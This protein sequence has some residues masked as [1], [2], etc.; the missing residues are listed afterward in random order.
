MVDEGDV[1]HS[2]TSVRRDICL[3]VFGA[4][5]QFVLCTTGK[6]TTALSTGDVGI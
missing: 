6:L 4:M 1:T 2:V 5:L 3:P